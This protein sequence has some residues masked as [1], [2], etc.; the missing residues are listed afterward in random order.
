V[1]DSFVAEEVDVDWVNH[2]ENVTARVRKRLTVNNE[3]PAQPTMA[4]MR[5]TAARL[6]RVIGE[7]LQAGVRL[8]ACGSRWSF[9]NIPVVADGWII[10]A[11]RLDWRFNI[12]IA[13][14]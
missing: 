7:A 5:A 9:S 6:Q 10:E 14:P 3:V 13:D 2:H 4:G 12:S 1:P 11:S 8:R